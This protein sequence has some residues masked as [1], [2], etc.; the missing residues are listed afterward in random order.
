MCGQRRR[1]KGQVEVEHTSLRFRAGA[2]TRACL[3]GLGL[4][5][6]ATR[7]RRGA[8]DH[9]AWPPAHG[10]VQLCERWDVC[11]ESNA[12]LEVLGQRT[13]LEVQGGQLGQS[14]QTHILELGDKIAVG[15]ARQDAV[16]NP[17]S[18]RIPPRCHAPTGPPGTACGP[19]LPAR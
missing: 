9:G 17:P 18:P 6:N 7:L 3:R 12:I 1:W 11:R 5:Q 2:H 16:R 15:L 13:V 4:V 14:A 8:D 19:A 10:C